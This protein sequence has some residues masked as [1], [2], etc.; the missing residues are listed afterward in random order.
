VRNPIE[1][2]SIS[3]VEDLDPEQGGPGLRFD[4][5]LGIPLLLAVILFAGWQW[6]R[7]EYQ[8]G[9]YRAG[10][11]AAQI[12]DWEAA[13]RYFGEAAGYADADALSAGIREKIERRDR[14][15]EAAAGYSARGEWLPALRDSRAAAEVQP[16]FRNLDELQLTALKHV[17]A[18][19][20][21]GTVAMRTAVEPAG[22][23]YRSA[24]NWVWMRGSDAHSNLLAQN[25]HGY[26]IYD[27]PDEGWTEPDVRLPGRNGPYARTS[28]FRGRNVT[29]AYVGGDEFAYTQL[30]LDPSYYVPFISGREGVWAAH[31]A[32]PGNDEYNSLV[33]RNPFYSREAA[34][35]PYPGGI[36]T[37]LA[38]PASISSASGAAIVSVDHNSRRYLLAEWTGAHPRGAGSDTIVNLFLCE[39][40]EA[41][42]RLVYTHRGG[43]LQSAQVSPD[44]RFVVVHTFTVG[45][46]P[47]S[48]DQ[49]TVLVDVQEPRR[50]ATLIT[51]TVP[52][53]REGDIL[54]AMTSTFIGQGTLAGDLVLSLYLGRNTH[55]QLIDPA[56]DPHTVNNLVADV[57]VEGSVYKAWEVI[58]Q[59][60]TGV[61]I[62]GQDAATP[63][64]PATG[65]LTI[66]E[67]DARGEHTA[68][69]LE[70]SSFSGI[71]DAEVVGDL[72]LWTNYE[73]G[74]STTFG[75][76]H[77][78]VL[79]LPRHTYAGE[80]ATQVFVSEG[81]SS[82]GR[83][84]ASLH[85]GSGLLAYT[86]GNGL[87]VRTYDSG[88][89]LEL[90]P[91][92]PAIF[93]NVANS[94]YVGWMR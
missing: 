77:R 9:Q 26:I 57:K 62:A 80:G 33:V 41:T 36:S 45:A 60:D 94:Y 38:I 18:D 86:H 4:L 2:D 71:V 29:Q 28:A 16:G 66:I 54:S 76:P 31:F 85:L 73:Y 44:G 56:R 23:Y 42:R 22:L 88:I 6:W 19:A 49:T 5:L 50:T 35:L 68:Y 67:L 14:L 24:D 84:G 63:T 51:M 13:L 92:V 40:G 12:S 1:E 47:G 65:T 59:S 17:Y 55:V 69:N 87:H 78:S 72:L 7:Q 93:E 53:A 70:V 25:E 61:L 20:L 46:E 39:A 32:F 48:E 10:Q 11:E 90:E 89:D 58:E 83:D 21:S 79:S 43:G 81:I 34:F 8:S 52:A 3:V 15:Y 91:G 82:T 74:P 37:T 64:M 75:A 30:P 27:V